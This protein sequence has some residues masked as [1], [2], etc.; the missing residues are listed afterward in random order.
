[1]FCAIDNADAE[2]GVCVYD[3]PQPRA[4]RFAVNRFHAQ[5]P[6]GIDNFYTN[7]FPGFYE[8]DFPVKPARKQAV[9]VSDVEIFP[10]NRAALRSGA[11]QESN[12]GGKG[13]REKFFHERES[14]G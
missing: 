2:I 8:L 13:K 12:E 10:V 14:R 5:M 11:K 7:I 1:M 3:L 6:A 9:I 4:I